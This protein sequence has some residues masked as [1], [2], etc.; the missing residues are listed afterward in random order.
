M[1][2]PIHLDASLVFDMLSILQVKKNQFAAANNVEKYNQASFN[3]LQLYKDIQQVLDN[4]TIIDI[5]NSPEYNRLFVANK[6]VFEIVGI[7]ENNPETKVSAYE[8]AQLNL[9]RYKYKQE[10]QK[11]FFETDISEVKTG[12]YVE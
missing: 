6:M 3:Y 4:K 8:I 2:I 9:L 11:K 7:T 12:K 1:K 10:L 5:L